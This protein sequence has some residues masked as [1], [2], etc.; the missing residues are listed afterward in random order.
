MLKV[1]SKDKKSVINKIKNGELTSI[2]LSTTNLVDEVI[3]AMHTHGILDCLSYGI[4]DERA[5]NTTVPYEII[6]ASSIAAK[7]KVHTSMTDIPYALSDHK[8]L[9][10]LGYNLVAKEGIGR[11]LMRESTLRF[12]IGKYTVDDL[13][14]GYNVTIQNFIIPKMN[15]EAD[16][17]ILDCTDLE[18]CFKNPRYEGSGIGH[19]KRDANG[20]TM[21]A[22]GYKLSTLRGIVRD[23]GIIEEIRLG[24]LNVNDLSLS[25]EMLYTTSVLKPGDILINDRGFLSREVINHLKKER[26]VDSYIPV[27]PNMQIYKMAVNYAKQYGKWE[28]LRSNSNE[29]VCLVDNMG[30]FWRENHYEH[31]TDNY[32]QDVPLNTCVLWDIRYDRY[33]VFVTTDLA[34]TAKG[35]VGIYSLRHE[36]EEDYRQLKDFWKLEDFKSTKLNVIAFHIVSVLFG[37]LFFQIYTMLPE[38][39][40]YTRKSLP[41]ILKNYLVQVQGYIVAYVGDN[42]GVLTLLELMELYAES[43]DSVREIIKNIMRR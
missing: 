4:V 29:R 19:S 7:M 36:I 25:K 33:A 16:I 39:E 34:Q 5:E 13:I 14:Q 30:V 26:G 28:R 38:G 31:R 43:P 32:Y 11:S 41:V 24:P 8:T 42:F 27:N 17:H 9:A 23:N 2:E 3:I 37:Y 20:E 10:E 1:C 22:R 40:K 12:L 15:I 35:I 6:W 21:L 18:V